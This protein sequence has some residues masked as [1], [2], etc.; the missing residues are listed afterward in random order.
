[1]NSQLTQP[2]ITFFSL[3]YVDYLCFN[4]R[5]RV[6]AVSYLNCLFLLKLCVQRLS[7]LCVL[8]G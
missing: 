1:M 5:D 4:F 2:H 8:N 6:Q 3:I 7:S